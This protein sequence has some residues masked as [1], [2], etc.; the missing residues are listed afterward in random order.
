MTTNQYAQK[1]MEEILKLYEQQQ[2]LEAYQKQKEAYRQQMLNT[3]KNTRSSLADLGQT[4]GNSSNAKIANIGDKLYSASGQ[5]VIN[6]LKSKGSDIL[7]N[8]W[9]NAVSKAGNWLG[10]SS[11]QTLANLGSKLSGLGSSAGSSTG[12]AAGLGNAGITAGTGALASNLSPA[13]SS[14]LLGAAGAGLLAYNALKSANDEKKAQAMQLSANAAQ[15]GQNTALNNKQTAMQNLSGYEGTTGGAASLADEQ[16]NASSSDN[17]NSALINEIKNQ[18]P[19]F[20]QTSNLTPQ[21]TPENESLLQTGLNI[22][23][24]ANTDEKTGIIS[25]ILRAVTG[26]GDNANTSANTFD[27]AGNEALNAEVQNTTPDIIGEYQQ[28]LRDNG[29]SDDVVNGVSQ[30]LNGGYKEIDDWIK[31]YNQGT[32][33]NNPIN[34]PQTEDEIALAREGKFNV[35]QENIP[36]ENIPEA[37]Q[38]P[39]QSEKETLIKNIFN[40]FQKG[41]TENRTTGFAPENLERTEKSGWN[42]LGEAVGTGARVLSN[43]AL[44][45]LVAGS[46]YGANSKDWAKGLEYGVNWARDKAKSD[47]YNKL[48]TEQNA[49]PILGCG[50]S[51]TDYGAKSLA[52][53]REN[54]IDYKNN[55]LES[56]LNKTNPKLG[57]Y[58][59]AQLQSG[60]MTTDEYNEIVTHPDY[61]PD[62]RINLKAIETIS[63]KQKNDA[64]ITHMINQDENDKLNTNIK[65]DAANSYIKLNEAKINDMA[66]KHGIS[67]REVELKEKELAAQIPLIQARIAQINRKE[68]AGLTI[69]EAEKIYKQQMEDLNH[70]HDN[71]F[72]DDIQL[73]NGYNEASLAFNNTVNDIKKAAWKLTNLNLPNI[74][75]KSR[76]LFQP[77]VQGNKEQVK[78]VNQPLKIQ[79]IHR[80]LRNKKKMLNI[81]IT[82]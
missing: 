23:E 2:E 72:I 71:G 29:Y 38:T 10:N 56:D 52:N 11:N 35:S 65:K 77:Q 15:E 63:N 49:A 53:Y 62:R 32:G 70:R 30:G 14:S 68:Y 22:P 7:N 48:M 20:N 78:Q 13:L 24:S 75:P 79:T 39:E 73:L 57:D 5:N 58:L 1:R 36:Q 66:F 43:P 31:Q 81:T 50:L 59:G 42:R 46:I 60:L 44:Q 8:T 34:I 82:L 80:C 51:S 27:N 33:S 74:P 41:Y 54:T 55:K 21:N 45:G 17:N 69:S 67:T 18:L 4:L 61:N 28:Q 47:M 16:Y 37:E 9:N 6:S 64:S 26:G 12:A 3:A 40:E 19:I 76:L 25:S